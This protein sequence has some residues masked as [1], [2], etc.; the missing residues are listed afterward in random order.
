MD[1]PS[2]ETNDTECA[3]QRET[4]KERKCVRVFSERAHKLQVLKRFRNMNYVQLAC[5]FSAHDML[6]MCYLNGICYL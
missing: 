3:R 2:N 1:R 4:E 6:K 5:N